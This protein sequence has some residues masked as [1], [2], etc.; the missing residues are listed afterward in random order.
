[1]YSFSLS[2]YVLVRVISLF[3]AFH[4]HFS[5]FFKTETR[6]VA[7]RAQAHPAGQIQSDTRRNLIKFSHCVP[8]INEQAMQHFFFD[9]PWKDAPLI[10]QLQRNVD[11]LIGDL[12]DDALILDES[13]FPKQRKHSVGVKRQYCGALGKVGNCQLGV[14][15]AY[16]NSPNTTPIDQRLYLPEH[17]ANDKECRRKTGVPEDV[18]FKTKAQLGLEMILDGHAS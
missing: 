10:A 17:R 9:S 4:E 2:K 1:M 18:A 14:F 16:A 11:G 3:V 15:L 7:R 12:I 8:K 5:Q 6:S 13:G